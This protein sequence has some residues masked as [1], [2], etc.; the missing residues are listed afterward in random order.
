MP[1]SAIDAISPAFQHAK[2]QLFH[3]FRFGQ[4]TRLALVGLLAGE[5][6]SSG[7]CNVPSNFQMPHTRGGGS[8]KFMDAGVW[9]KFGQFWHG[10]PALIAGLITIGI[11][12]TVV[13]WLVFIYLNSRMRFVLFDSVIA[14]ECHIREYWSRRQACAWRYFLWLLLFTLCSFAVLVIFIGIPLGIAWVAGWLR[15]PSEHVLP[16]VLGGIPLFFLLLAIFI[17]AAVIGVMTKDFVVP[18][19]A[20]EDISAM[21]GW[22]RLWAAIKTEK[23][24]YAGYIGMKIVLAIAAGIIFGIIAVIV[25]VILAIPLV[26]VGVVVVLVAAKSALAWNVVTISL[27]VI[28]ACVCFAVLLYLIAFISVPVAVFFPAYSYHFLASRYPRLDALLHPAPPAPPLPPA[29]EIPPPMPPPLLPP[30]PHAIG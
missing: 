25:M 1:L 7:G 14:K 9:Q 29:P 16:L 5:L 27:V 28:A 21:E 24:S 12:V 22:R 18:Y 4:W 10:H 8:D 30:E 26:I 13:L 6:G 3:P 19:M 15:D 11:V 2:K 20:I 17:C 23:G